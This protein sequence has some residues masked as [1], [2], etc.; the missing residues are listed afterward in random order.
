[1]LP[2]RIL[3]LFCAGLTA[4]PGAG[5][6]LSAPEREALE[7]ISADSLRGHVSFLASDLLEGRAT[8]SRGL[9]IAAEYIAAQFRRAG[10]EPAGDDGYFQTAK[11]VE[12]TPSLE[13]FELIIE[14]AGRTLRVEPD[15]VMVENRGA[16]HIERAGVVKVALDAAKPLEL[17][18]EQVEGKVLLAGAPPP[19]PGAFRQLGALLKLAERLKPAAVVAL[20]KHGGRLTGSR[21]QDSTSRRPPSVMV[22]DEALQREYEAMQPGATGALAS[23]HIAAPKEHPVVLRNVAA[24]LRGSDPVLKDSYVLL[25]AHY[26]HKGV[27]GSGDGDSIYNGANDDASGTASVIEVAA[28]LAGLEPRPK[29]SILFIAFFGEERGEIG[30]TYYARHPL[31]PLARTVA[32][33]NLEQLGRTDDSEGPQIARA[34]VTGYDYS[35][36]G[37]TLSQAGQLT[38]VEV[39]R[40][41]KHSDEY[42]AA[43]D[44]FPLAAA[45][46]PAHTVSVS[47]LFPDYHRPGDE[48]QKLDYAN[49]QKIDRMIAAGLILIAG[50]PQAPGWN[51]ASPKAE[52]YVKAAQGLTP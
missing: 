11:F 9:D 44:N 20:W 18:A 22:D 15:K 25:S 6:A 43:S 23:L 36:I 40:H 5:T 24:R 47:Y 37:E 16:V 42:F 46:V 21:L 3:F 34:A 1:M 50:N 52:P 26:D 8:P 7:H 14:S 29:R 35:D 4:L 30:S 49:M 12:S 45:G 27:R 39:F 19:G 33:I 32:A 17:T 13:G 48:W 28:A 31:E 10:L 51:H 2:I 38:G 41:P